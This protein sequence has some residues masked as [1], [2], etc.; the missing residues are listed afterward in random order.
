MLLLNVFS[1]LRV[2]ICTH[3]LVLASKTIAQIGFFFL[4]FESYYCY[5]LSYG[6]PNDLNEET[7]QGGVETSEKESGPF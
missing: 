7:S 6:G 1:V 4:I 5:Y 2:V 3:L